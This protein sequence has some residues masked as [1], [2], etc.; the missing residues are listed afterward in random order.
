MPSARTEEAR[1]GCDLTATRCASIPLTAESRFIP[2]RS[3]LGS[4]RDTYHQLLIFAR[5][6]TTGFKPVN[7]LYP[8]A[9]ETVTVTRLPAILC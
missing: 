9:D 4:N 7:R 6:K 8:H 1:P 5:V 3:W 2:H